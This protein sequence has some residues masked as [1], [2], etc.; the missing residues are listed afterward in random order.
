MKNL[1]TFESFINEGFWDDLNGYTSLG[2]KD[3][4]E[5]SGFVVGD[6]V[7]HLHKNLKGE[8]IQEVPAVVDEVL[9]SKDGNWAIIVKKE[10]G[11][12]TFGTDTN[13]FADIKDLKK[14]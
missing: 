1:K 3:K 6:K 13:K 5:P 14:V 8:V 9:L 12:Q 2:N 4:Q 10:N 11:R 7:H